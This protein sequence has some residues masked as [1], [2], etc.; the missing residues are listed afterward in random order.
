MMSWMR[1]GQDELVDYK[2]PLVSCVLECMMK[3]LSDLHNE[4]NVFNSY[5]SYEQAFC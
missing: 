3:C 4:Q 5:V 1:V 2:H